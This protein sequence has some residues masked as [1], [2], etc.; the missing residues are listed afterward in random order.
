MKAII[1]TEP[2]EIRGAQFVTGVVDQKCKH[3]RSERLPAGG[4]FVEIRHAPFTD[5]V[6]E[7]VELV[8]LIA[9]SPTLKPS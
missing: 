8:I 4:V 6:K 7:L 9:S 1:N 5:Y 3:R 2:V